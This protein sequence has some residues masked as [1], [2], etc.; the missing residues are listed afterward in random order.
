MKTLLAVFILACAI[1]A[2]QTQTN[3]PTLANIPAPISNAP[4]VIK[5]SSATTNAVVVLLGEDA[6]KLMERSNQDSF[7][8]KTLFGSIV[9]ALVGVAAEF[10]RE[11]RERR[12]KKGDEARFERNTILA[13]RREL[14][15]MGKLYE[16]E[17]G[18][19]VDNTPIPKILPAAFE[20]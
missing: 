16:K 9:A 10:F 19:I 15:A 6:R 4:I 2:G 3:P 7:I 8:K 1:A 13:I 5:T 20:H 12:R 14:E 17:M 11:W 18:A